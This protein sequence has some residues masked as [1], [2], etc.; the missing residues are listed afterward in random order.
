MNQN[1]CDQRQLGTNDVLNG[2]GQVM[3]VHGADTDKYYGVLINKGANKGGFG[4]FLSTVP[5][6]YGASGESG[7]VSLQP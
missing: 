6:I 3:A 2:V 5:L 4:Y 7:G 1:F